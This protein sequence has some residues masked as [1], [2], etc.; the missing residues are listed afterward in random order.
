MLKP[1]VNYVGTINVIQYRKDLILITDPL[2]VNWILN[3]L[4]Y[5]SAYDDD[6]FE[7][8]GLFVT[9]RNGDYEE[10]FAFE[11]CVPYLYKDLWQIKL[12]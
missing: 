2:E 8:S 5:P 12:Q 4:G 10:V 9:I 1:I 3:Y 6:T 11:G 7:F